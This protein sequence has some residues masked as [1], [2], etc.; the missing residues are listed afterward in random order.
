MCSFTAF[1]R[2]GQRGLKFN[3]KVILGLIERLKKITVIRL[4]RCL[5]QER[6][7]LPR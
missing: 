3:F 7:L 2:L 6:P 1:W 4:A 5:S